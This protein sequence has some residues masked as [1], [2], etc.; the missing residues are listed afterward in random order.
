[1]LG[2]LGHRR[3]AINTGVLYT[4]DL[5]ATEPGANS[6]ANYTVNWGDGSVTTEA[7]TGTTTAVSHAYSNVG[8]TYAVTFAAN[9]ASGSVTESDLVVSNFIAGSDAIF[10]FDGTSGESNGTFDSTTGALDQ[11]YGLTVGPDGN[12]YVAGYE[13]DNIVRFAPDGSY[14]GVFT[15]DSRLEDPTSVTWGSDGKL[16]VSNYDD[17]NILRFE[18]DGDF[19]SVFSAGGELNGPEDLAFGPDGDLYVSSWQ[20]SKIV[21]IDGVNG[22]AGTTVLDV[23]DGVE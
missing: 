16:Y 19:D 1:M 11:P 18:A 4:L 2:Y 13:S 15:N 7:Y 12:F 17:D 10:A 20:N 6:I 21:V 14:L 22:G 8:N 5:I 23:G 9:E 3:G